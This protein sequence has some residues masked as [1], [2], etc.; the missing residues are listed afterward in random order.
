MLKVKAKTIIAVL[1]EAG[2]NIDKET[3]KV[4]GMTK[5]E[6]QIMLKMANKIIQNKGSVIYTRRQLA[7]ELKIHENNLTNPIKKLTEEGYLK[8]TI[9]TNQDGEKS[10]SRTYELG[11]KFKEEEGTQEN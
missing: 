3:K 7:N 4:V 5:N 10:Y 8:V 9:P 1:D 6:Y 2:L 11:S